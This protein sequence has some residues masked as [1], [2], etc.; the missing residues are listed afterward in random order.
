MS[1]R[2]RVIVVVSGV[3]LNKLR[4]GGISCILILMCVDVFVCFYVVLYSVV[5][6]FPKPRLCVYTT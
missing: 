3:V 1:V 4:A 2:R 6:D 5:L